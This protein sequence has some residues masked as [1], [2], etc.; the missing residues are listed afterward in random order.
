MTQRTIRTKHFGE[1]E[2]PNNGEDLDYCDS[3]TL[4]LDGEERDVDLLLCDTPSEDRIRT[5]ESLL[6]R[7][8]ELYQQGRKAIFDGRET[9]ERV[10]YFIDSHIDE[11][12]DLHEL[13]DVPS[14]NNITPELFVQKLELRAVAMHRNNEDILECVL[15][16]VLPD[17]YSS[18]I[19]V[20]CLDC[21]GELLYIIQES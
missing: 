7:I 6:D 2:V 8:H 16:F 15:D 20:V 12:E 4:T 9:D 21:Q 11:L 10:K 5:I 18:E 1:I 14:N 19:L 17:D 13:F 3:H